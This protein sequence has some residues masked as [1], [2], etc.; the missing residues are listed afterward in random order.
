MEHYRP[1]E[2]AALERVAIFE[3]YKKLNK[4]EKN[5]LNGLADQLLTSMRKISPA[6]KYGFGEQS[7]IEL[8]GKLG[9]FGSKHPEMWDIISGKFEHYTLPLPKYMVPEY[10]PPRPYR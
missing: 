5:I 10:R 9:M 2:D 7:A 3:A 6:S 8:L 4:Q 1:T